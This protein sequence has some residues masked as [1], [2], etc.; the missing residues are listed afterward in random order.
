M[1]QATGAILLIAGMASGTEELVWD[2][3][4]SDVKVSARAR[5]EGGAELGVF[6]RF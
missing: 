4:G 3:L 6:G 2:G 5:P 1:I